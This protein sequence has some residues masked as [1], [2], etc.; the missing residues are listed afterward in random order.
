MVTCAAEC[1]HIDRHHEAMSAID[2]CHRPGPQ[3]L[4]REPKD[5]PAVRI[6]AAAE[7][8]GAWTTSDPAVL[9]AL[10][11]FHVWTQ[12]YLQTRHAAHACMR[13]QQPRV[14]MLGVNVET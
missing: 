1:Q 4:R 3:A 11:P 6:E 13:R 2:L 5:E 8:T 14:R 7:V 12:D 9:A 10:D